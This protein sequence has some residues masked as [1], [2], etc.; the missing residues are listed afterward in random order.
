MAIGTVENTNGLL[1]QHFPGKM[2]F[3]TIPGEEI[4]LVEDRINNQTR[5]VLNYQL[6]MKVFYDLINRCTKKFNP[7]IWQNERQ[8]KL[9]LI[10][11]ISQSFFWRLDHNLIQYGSANYIC[12]RPSSDQHLHAILIQN[13]GVE[14][15]D[16]LSFKSFTSNYKRVLR[17]D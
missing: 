6:P 8:R 7:P 10:C 9:N 4:Q 3:A 2:D 15:R 17:F 1:R 11:F 5:K 13:P 14:I 12:T 16:H